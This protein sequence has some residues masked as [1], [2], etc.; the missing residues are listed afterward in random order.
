[1]TG[2]GLAPLEEAG[3]AAAALRERAKLPV[4][5]GFGIDSAEKARIVKAQGVDGVAVG[6]AVVK[7]IAGASSD[8]DAVIA[9]TRLVRELRSGLDDTA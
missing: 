4:V 3:Q 6:T 2:S 1:V 9:V 8:D 5:V 7:A